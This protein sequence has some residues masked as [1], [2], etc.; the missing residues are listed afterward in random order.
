MVRH[1]SFRKAA[2]ELFLTQPTVSIPIKKLSEVVGLPLFEQVGKRIHLT[3]SGKVL[4]KAC[5]E[6]SNSLANLEP[7]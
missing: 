7:I 3:P 6:I 5:R 4:Y 1:S 2:E